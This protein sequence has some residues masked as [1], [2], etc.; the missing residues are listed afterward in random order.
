MEG[1]LL[2]EKVMIQVIVIVNT[3]AAISTTTCP[4]AQP[5]P[6]WPWP[7]CQLYQLRLKAPLLSLQKPHRRPYGGGPQL[8]MT[9]RGSVHWEDISQGGN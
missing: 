9:L 5:I 4:Q 3:A 1:A 7:P 2:A 6:C 8:G